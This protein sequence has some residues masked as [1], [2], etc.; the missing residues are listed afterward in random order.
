M[1]NRNF[2]YLIRNLLEDYDEYMKA[3]CREFDIPQTSLA[4]L[5]FLANNPDTPTAKDIVRLRAIKANL[6]SLHVAKLVH[7]GYLERKAVSGDRRQI[8]LTCTPKATKI[9]ERGREYQANFVENITRGLS[10][11]DI[12][13]MKSCVCRLLENAG[14]IAPLSPKFT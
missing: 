8:K 7:D 6:V 13:H 10:D 14:N 5:L 11:A 1:Q 3:A 9:I 12:A 2:L 4:I